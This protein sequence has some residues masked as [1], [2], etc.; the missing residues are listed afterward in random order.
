MGWEILHD[1]KQNYAVF[2][3]NTDD[4]P[5]GKL[6]RTG[7]GFI[8]ESYYAWFTKKGLDPRKMTAESL[9]KEIE[10]LQ[11]L[12]NE[13]ELEAVIVLSQGKTRTVSASIDSFNH[14]VSFPYS[15]DYTEE[16]YDFHEK[17]EEYINDQIKNL[18]FC[19]EDRGIKWRI[20]SNE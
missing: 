17:A 18:N 1:N 8:K 9:E 16:D 4:E 20:L 11:M 10:T 7:Y 13:P 12:D 2:F 15:D 5:F 14:K 3:C 19:G 6:F